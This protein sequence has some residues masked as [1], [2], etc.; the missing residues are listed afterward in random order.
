MT[1]RRKSFVVMIPRIQDGQGGAAVPLPSWSSSGASATATP[2]SLHMVMSLQSGLF[3]VLHRAQR[4]H[5]TRA[6]DGGVILFLVAVLLA[7]IQICTTP[8]WQAEGHNTSKLP[9][10]VDMRNS[11]EVHANVVP[12]CA[13]FWPS[14][15]KSHSR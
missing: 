6:F 3:Y 12:V 1:E 10:A 2:L 4:S 5:M 14:F 8:Y 13:F 15:R 9:D 7:P 11:S